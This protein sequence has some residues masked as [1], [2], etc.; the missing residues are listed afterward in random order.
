MPGTQSKAEYYRAHGRHIRL[1]MRFNCTPQEARN[2]MEA[3]IARMRWRATEK[4]LDALRNAE[5][6]ASTQSE[7]S[8]PVR[9]EPWMMRDL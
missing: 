2:R 4:R 5:I 9:D 1:A 3:R 6:K 7:Q 8:A